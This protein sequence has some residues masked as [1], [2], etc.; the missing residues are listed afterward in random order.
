MDSPGWLT[1][2]DST[3][4]HTVRILLSILWQSSILLGMVAILAYILR[5]KKESV[6]Y[7]LWVA[8]ILIIPILPLLTFGVAKIGTPR[9]ELSVIPAYSIPQ[10]NVVQSPVESRA[11]VPREPQNDAQNELNGESLDSFI[12]PSILPVTTQERS[13]NTYRTSI[14]DYPWALAFSGYI[15]GVAM[16]LLLIIIGRL[17]IRNWIV[18]GY[19]VMDPHIIEIFQ[20]VRERLKI[21]REIVIIENEHIPAPL[22]C[23]TFKPVIILPT[24]FFR[25]KSENDL[26]A[27]AVHEIS[28]I[29]RNDVVIFSLLSLVKAV[30]FFH[31][32]VWLATHQASYLAEIACDNA[33]VDYTKESASYAKMLTMIAENLPERAFSIELAAGIIFSKSSFFHRIEAILHNHGE[34]IRRLSRLAL[35]GTVL[36]SIIS[37]VIA[38]S[39]PIG[40]ARETGEMVTFSGKVTYNFEPVPGAVIYFNDQEMGFVEKVG[41]TD[42]T[43]SYTFEIESSVLSGWE[44]LQ[45]AVIAYSPKYSLGWQQ[46]FFTTLLDNIDIQLNDPLSIEGTIKD[47]SGNP[48]R[49]VEVVA[50]KLWYNPFSVMIQQISFHKNNIIPLISKTDKNGYFVLNNLPPGITGFFKVHRKGYADE[51]YRLD[52][53]FG[54]K[55]IIT[56]KPENRIEGKI[57]YRDSGAPAKNLKVI[58]PPLMIEDTTDKNGFYSLPNM[59]EYPVSIYVISDVE[60]KGI[61][62]IKENI[63]LKSGETLTGIDFTLVQGGII[64]GRV[65]D[66]DTGEPIKNHRIGYYI[67]ERFIN[68]TEPAISYTTTDETGAFRFQSIPGKACVVTTAPDGYEHGLMKKEVDV[69]EGETVTVDNFLFKKSDM[70]QGIVQ[71]KDGKPVAEAI[72]V[73]NGGINILSG[74]DGIFNL[75]G[76]VNGEKLI[77]WAIHPELKVRGVN[78][79]EFTH[80]GEANIICEPFETTSITGRVIDFND[81]PVPYASIAFFRQIHNN[82]GVK[83]A[84]TLTDRNGIYNIDE[85]IIGDAYNIL[86]G[87]KGYCTPIFINDEN[88][89]TARENMPPLKDIILP[90]AERILEGTITDSEGNPIFG[91][92]IS[93]IGMSGYRTAITDAKGNYFL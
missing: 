12:S 5:R 16:F 64:T 22:T 26:L 79:I 91:A 1:I 49:G 37:L 36:A 25:N 45:P 58:F 68:T 88:I 90:K 44:R 75:R 89:F 4:F 62:A 20:G 72:I 47:T 24:G 78:D 21:S 48:V 61:V 18:S 82:M 74:K 69:V 92:V 87:K 85:L 19:A 27:V 39:F 84:W 70:L 11:P 10:V 57:T 41:K 93:E 55:V 15:I 7:T 2:I 14:T 32:L 76:F 29:K 54:S 81:K 35:A 23:R 3:G 33:V 51:L 86:A 17:R 60:D 83:K 28:H 31:P 46:I 53:S 38:L 8:A 42:K 66:E 67:Y 65:I 30:F 40:Y 59:P 13:Q 71:T 63:P 43:G 77:L 6:R 52:N 56:L 50:N 9:K 80:N 34:K 73:I